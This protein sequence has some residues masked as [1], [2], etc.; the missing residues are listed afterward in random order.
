MAERSAPDAS[1]HAPSPEPARDAKTQLLRTKWQRAQA[2]GVPEAELIWNYAR[3]LFEALIER[4]EADAARALWREELRDGA[5]LGSLQPMNRLQLLRNRIRLAEIE[6]SPDTWYR[7]GQRY[8]NEASLASELGHAG[9]DREI[10]VAHLEM[11]AALQAMGDLE[12]ALV[13]Y[14]KGLTVIRKLANADRD[15]LALRSDL[16]VAQDRVGDVLRAQGDMPASLLAYRS[17]QGI[18]KMLVEAEPGNPIWRRDL[19]VSHGKVGNIMR[20]Q[21]QL[22]GALKAYRD[23]LARIEQLQQESPHN[24]DLKADGGVVELKIGDVLRA[25]GHLPAALDAY[26]RAHATYTHLVENSARSAWQRVKA[27]AETR[28]T[29]VRSALDAS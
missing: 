12:G 24:L 19:S 18:R 2:K 9:A 28:T 17:S 22:D 14:R 3:P 13:E 15:H 23:S 25:Q 10:F 11:G 1:A 21:G 26:E 7:V 16:A 8:F 20:A 29:I 27:M 4:G 6:A 5:A